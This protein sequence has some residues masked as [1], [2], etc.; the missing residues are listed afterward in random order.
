MVAYV[1][2]EGGLI[3][4]SSEIIEW[5]GYGASILIAISL[6]MTNIIK[7]RIINSIGCVMFI[8]YGMAVKSYPVVLSNLIIIFINIYN[9]YKLKK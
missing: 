8:I 3:M 6:M 9:L 4:F 1:L 7:L 5:I 2:L